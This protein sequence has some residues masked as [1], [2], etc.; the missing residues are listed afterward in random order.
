MEFGKF[1]VSGEDKKSLSS[2]KNVLTASGHIFIGYVKEPQ[3]ILRHI[4]GHTPDLVVIDIGS[5]FRELRPTLEVLDEEMLTACILLLE[6]R[7][8]EVFEFLTKTRSMTYMAKPVFEEVILQMSDMVLMNVKRLRE[9]ESKVKKLNDTLESR[10][11]IEKAKWI[12]VE[13]QGLRENE[14]YEI[15]KKKSRNNRIPMRDIADAIIMTRG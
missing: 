10:K 14:A 7:N 8:D 13:Q 5:H 6:S 1:I 11:R 4:R 15:I 3:A 2:I 9:Y 12:L